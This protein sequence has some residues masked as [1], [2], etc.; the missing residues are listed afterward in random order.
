MP[1][2]R[3]PEPVPARVE[4]EHLLLLSEHLEKLANTPGALPEPLPTLYTHIAA[5]LA[6]GCGSQ[7]T[8]AQ[9]HCALEQAEALYA[10]IF[11]SKAMDPLS[12][13]MLNL[14]WPECEPEDQ[15]DEDEGK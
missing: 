5:A 3:Q 7:M 2:I 10:N 12:A 4:K 11:E 1:I 15:D 6:R 9:F 13:L 14:S 8:K